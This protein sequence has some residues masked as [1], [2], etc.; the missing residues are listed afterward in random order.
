MWQ[1][2]IT[3]L[4]QDQLIIL[5]LVIG[6]CS[7]VAVGIVACQWR[8]VRLAQLEANLKMQML[9]KGMS[10]LDI[11]RILKV[12]PSTNQ[13]NEEEQAEFT[14]DF[15]ADKA[16]L[17]EILV[18]HEYSADDIERL[19]QNLH[20]TLRPEKAGVIKMLVENETKM[21]E[22][23]KVVNAFDAADQGVQ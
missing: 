17:V 18:N 19:L 12:N 11:E 4:V 23:E 15:F 13:S 7:V 6:S 5:A 2:W 3:R 1:E 9:N 8:R 10:S 22:I 14:G 16:K 21:E 20:G